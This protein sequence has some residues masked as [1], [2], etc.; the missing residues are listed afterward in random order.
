MQEYLYAS[1]VAHRW[2]SSLY[3]LNTGPSSSTRAF[4]MT[5]LSLRVNATFC[6][7]SRH[8]IKPSLSVQ[9][10]LKGDR[11]ITPLSARIDRLFCCA[12]G[13]R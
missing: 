9:E 1:S 10:Q 11:V 8:Q 13:S 12:R 3:A 4:R 6:K 2:R 7:R 5:G